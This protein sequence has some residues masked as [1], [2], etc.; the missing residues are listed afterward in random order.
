MAHV[1]HSMRRVS[2][3]LRARE[4]HLALLLATFPRSRP[5]TFG[6]RL[7]KKAWP[8]ILLPS[9]APGS[10]IQTGQRPRGMLMPAA[11]FFFNAGGSE[12]PFMFLSP[13]VTAPKILVGPWTMD[14]LP[15]KSSAVKAFSKPKP[16]AVRSGGAVPSEG[17]S[18]AQRPVLR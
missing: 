15:A 17:S 9:M 5:S 6:S 1:Q 12:L 3:H 2:K 16:S 8:G 18:D 10:N 7:I 4:R 14:P 13:N 11:E